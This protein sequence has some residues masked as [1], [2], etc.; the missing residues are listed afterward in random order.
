MRIAV[1]GDLHY[2][3]LP[4]QDKQMEQ[5][6]NQFYEQ[7]FQRLFQIEADYYVSIGDLTN[8]GT[9][10]ELEDVY[11]FIRKYDKHFIHVLGNHDV[12]GNRKEDVLTITGQTRYQAIST[13]HATLA[14]L[15]TTRDQDLEN[16]GGTLETNQLTWLENVVKDSGLLPL[17]IFGHHPVH[18]TTKNS[19]RPY[20]SIDAEIP[21]QEVLQKKTGTGIYINGHNHSNSIIEKDQW[22]FVQLAAVLDQQAVRV[23]D[24]NDSEINI[25][26]INL[27]TEDMK[28]QAQIIGGNITGFSLAPQQLGTAKDLSR[29]IILKQQV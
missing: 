4:F 23:F 22:T 26:T 27:S 11:H 12:Y 21:I 20:L 19:E 8:Y 1:F 7:F 3:E 10:R 29:S 24:I 5:I 2:P 15:D 16:W 14:F 6:R 17:L 9:N 13:N 18:Q 25:N 28:Q